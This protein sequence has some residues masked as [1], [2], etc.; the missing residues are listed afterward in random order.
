M[1]RLVHTLVKKVSKN[2]VGILE[3]PKEEGN[4]YPYNRGGFQLHG[5]DSTRRLYLNF[6]PVVGTTEYEGRTIEK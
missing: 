3:H 5:T 1:I 6:G 2:V 4:V